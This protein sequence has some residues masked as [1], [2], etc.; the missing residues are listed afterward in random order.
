V[1]GVT[2]LPS[3]DELPIRR[4]APKGAAWGVWGDDDVFGCLNLLTP[5]R[6]VAAAGLVR[7][8]AVFALNLDQHL[9][10]PP[11]FG[12]AAPEHTVLGEG[13]GHDDLLSFNTQSS[14]QWD[15]F[16]HVGSV[17]GFYNGIADEEHGIHHWARRG[18]AGRGVLADVARWRESVGRPVAPDAPDPIECDDIEATLE[19]QGTALQEGDV[20]L[21]RTGWLSWY[22]SLDARGRADTASSLKAPG[23]RPG[24]ATAKWMWDRHVAALA[25]DNPAVEVWPLGSLLGDLDPEQRRAMRNDPDAAPEIFVHTALLPLLGLPLGELWD[26]DP[27]AD[28]C[29]ADG[30]YEFL[31]TSAPLNVR[32][33]VAS[34]PNAL[35]IK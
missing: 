9:P 7:K 16:R 15:G 10:D 13:A 20:L 22:R 2:T 31:F 32:G 33:G 11:L 34:P 18:I 12:R 21:L 14:S 19:A 28:D 1:R 25:A 8:G 4:G 27:L 3:F 6:V 17:H 35:A 5:E 26:L 23:I 29:A 30:T 24:V